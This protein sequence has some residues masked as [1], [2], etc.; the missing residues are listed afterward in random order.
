MKQRLILRTAD[1]ITYVQE[2]LK[3]GAEGATLSETSVP[4]FGMPFTAELVIEVTRGKERTS[5]PLIHAI[6]LP[7][8]TYT[9]QEMEDMVWEDFREAC[10]ALAVKG[11]ERAVMMEEYLRKAEHYNAN[12]R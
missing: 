12:T 3:L 5:S 1:R 7:V 11:R 4:S 10:G 9:R 2:L 6:P 8:V